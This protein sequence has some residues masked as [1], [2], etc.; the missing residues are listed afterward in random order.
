MGMTLKE[1]LTKGEGTLSAQEAK[2]LAS[3]C[4]MDVETLYT[5]LEERGI[6]VLDNEAEEDTALDVDSIIAEV[7]NADGARRSADRS[8]RLPWLPLRRPFPRRPRWTF[9]CL[10]RRGPRC[11]SGCSHPLRTRSGRCSS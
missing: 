2:T 6:K 3:Q 8:R 11:N 9:R 5:L 7:E 1:L 4:R 10:L